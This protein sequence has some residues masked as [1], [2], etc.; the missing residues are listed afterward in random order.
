M[1]KS[2]QINI[3]RSNFKS[4]LCHWVVLL[5]KILYFHNGYLHIKTHCLGT[6]RQN[7]REGG[8]CNGLASHTKGVANSGM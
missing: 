6:C 1:V 2:L 3:V 8:T 5:G 4:G 7:P